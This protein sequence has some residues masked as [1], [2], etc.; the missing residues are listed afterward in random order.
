[1]EDFLHWLSENPAPSQRELLT[2]LCLQIDDASREALNQNKE[3]LVIGEFN[4]K[5]L[6]RM[7]R[8]NEQMRETG[9]TVYTASVSMLIDVLG[10]YLS[11]YMGDRPEGHLW[12]ILSCVFL[13]V[14]VKEPMH[15]QD[16]VHWEVAGDSTFRC[17]ARYLGKGSICRWCV[18]GTAEEGTNSHSE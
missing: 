8:L 6:L 2:E 16:I 13:S 14:V 7:L 12:I 4:R 1:M 10:A 3:G 18:C 11:A 5:T 9:E 17:P 15:P